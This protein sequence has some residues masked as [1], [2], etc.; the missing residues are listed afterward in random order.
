MKTE[1]GVS[2]IRSLFIPFAPR[3]A[4]AY[5]SV[6]YTH[7]WDHR[8]VETSRVSEENDGIEVVQLS[9][10]GKTN[11]TIK[12][13]QACNKDRFLKSQTYP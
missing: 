1:N 9:E 5:G 13:L 10:C 6:F 2:S 3:R 7:Q 8:T 11:Q 4:A 12:H